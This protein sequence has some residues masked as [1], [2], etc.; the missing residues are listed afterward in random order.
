MTHP[1]YYH[2]SIDAVVSAG[3]KRA[4]FN[5]T[6][7]IFSKYNQASAIYKVGEA[8]IKASGINYTIMR[9]SLIYGTDRDRNMT[10]LLKVLSRWPVFPVFGDGSALMQPVHVQDLADGIVATVLKSELTNGKEYNFCGPVA[11]SY[12]DLLE[13]ACKALGR[14]VYFVRV[15]HSLAVGGAAAL[16]AYR[17]SL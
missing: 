2:K 10:K 1:K 5:T 15:P 11:I 4:F 6:T 9:P 13:T 17:V 14:K 12:K 3:V 7:G 16:E 8:R